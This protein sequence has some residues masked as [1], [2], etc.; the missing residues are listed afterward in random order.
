MKTYWR[1][2]D[3]KNKYTYLGIKNNDYIIHTKDVGKKDTSLFFGSE[4]EA[5]EY[6]NQNLSSSE[7]IP[8]WIMVQD[9]VKIT[10]NL[11][12]LEDVCPC[13]GTYTSDGD[14]CTYC[15]KENGIYKRKEEYLD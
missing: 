11:F 10:R 1:I 3:K 2:V 12:A 15:Q 9:D 8:E 7:Y 6:I 4:K 13:C 14:V 5:Q